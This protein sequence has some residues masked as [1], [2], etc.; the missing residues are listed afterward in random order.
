M[1][2]G[3]QVDIRIVDAGKYCI[4]KK[5][6]WAEITKIEGEGDDKL[7]GGPDD[8]LIKGEDGQDKLYGNDGNDAM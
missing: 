4:T 2:V 1:S 6:L 5:W 8:D 7:Y 3:D